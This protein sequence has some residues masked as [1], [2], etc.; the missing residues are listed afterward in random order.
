MEDQPGAQRPQG[1]VPLELSQGTVDDSSSVGWTGEQ[2]AP[3]AIRCLSS[4]QS[5]ET[6]IDGIVNV[7]DTLI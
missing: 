5:C 1:S 2:I 6:D 3:L 7:I 4:L